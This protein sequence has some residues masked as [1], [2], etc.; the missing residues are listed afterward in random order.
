MKGRSAARS[1][2]IVADGDQ[3]LGQ[4]AKRIIGGAVQDSDLIIRIDGARA[5][6]SID[7]ADSFHAEA[8]QL[9][10]PERADARGAEDPNA[11]F[12]REQDLPV[13]DGG[14]VKE[15]PVGDADDIG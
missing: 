10:G 8:V 12:E 6:L 1:S 15:L 3:R 7:L 11:S 4:R 14:R 9:G 2:K 5:V 13:K